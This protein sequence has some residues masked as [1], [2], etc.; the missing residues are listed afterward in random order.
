MLSTKYR[1]MGILATDK[2]LKTKLY[3]NE[4]SYK[5][6]EF[7]HSLVLFRRLMLQILF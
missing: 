2:N 7:I 1:R 3:I 4:N 5:K 6:N